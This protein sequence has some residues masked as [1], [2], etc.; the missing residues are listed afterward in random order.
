ME[1]ILES[2]VLKFRSGDHPD[3]QGLF[4]GLATGQQPHTLFITC[5]D[6]RIDPALLTQTEPGELFVVRNAGNLVPPYGAGVT[7]EA[8]TIEYGVVALGV[9]QIV[10]CGHRRCG[11]MHAIQAPETLGALPTVAK[12]LAPLRDSLPAEGPLRTDLDTLI[13]WNAQQQLENLRT[14]PSVA[15]AER[16]GRLTL[17]AW[18]YDFVDASVVAYDPTAD[19]YGDLTA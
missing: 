3:R 5:S 4:D 14:H 16:E 17:K 11:A 7:N 1:A 6:S 12:A 13:Q 9:K 19:K 15:A 18:V 10:V 2:G 8:V